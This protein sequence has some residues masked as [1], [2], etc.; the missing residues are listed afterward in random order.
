VRISEAARGSTAQWIVVDGGSTDG[1]C[2]DL[3]AAGIQVVVSTKGRAVQM[4]AGASLADRSWVIFLHADTSL[5]AS[6]LEYFH[7]YVKDNA[8]LDGGAFTF[9]MDH[10]KFRYR[11]LEWYV[12]LRSRFLK[13]PF[14]DQ[15]IF[16]RKSVFEELGGFRRDLQIMEDL[17]FVHRLKKHGR[18]AILPVPAI[19]S[20][21]RYEEEGFFIRSFKNLIMQVLY[22][23]GFPASKLAA[24]YN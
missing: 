8:D 4:N 16:V 22:K 18:L 1:T 19:T 3:M 7:S 15:A 23:V 17:E 21:R 9:R 2:A 20:A 13:M 5:P 24:L 14:G 12:N 10:H 11:Y 6:S